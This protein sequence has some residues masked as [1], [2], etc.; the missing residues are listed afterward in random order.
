MRIFGLKFSVTRGEPQPIQQERERRKPSVT[1][2]DPGRVS[3]P[4][5]TSTGMLYTLKDFTQMVNPSFRVEVIQLI[6]DLYKVNPDMGKGMTDMMELTNT[7]HQVQFPNNSDQEAMAMNDHLNK[8]TKK[9]SNYTAGIDGLVNKMIAQIFI[10]GAISVEGVP[11]EDLTGLSTIVFVKP[12]T[13]VFKRE[14]NGVYQPYQHSVGNYLSKGQHNDY[15]KLNTQTYKYV[16][17]VNDT[18]E[19]YGIPP[20]MPALDS[21]KTQADMKVNIKH[22]MENAGI[23]GFM[24]ALMEK[25]VQ[26]ANE[27]V[28][29]Y[30]RRLDRELKKLKIRLREGMKDGLVVGYKDDHEFKMNST[31]KDMSNIDKPWT[32]NQQSVANGLGINSS[33]IGVNT[34]TTTEGGAG[35]NLSKLISQLKVIQM[36]LSHTL[37][38][39]YSLELRLAGFN[40]KGIKIVW[41]P[42]TVSDDVKIQQAKQYKVQNLNALYRDGIISLLQYAQEMGY[43][44]P[45]QDEPRVDISEQVNGKDKLATDDDKRQSDKSKSDRRVRDKNN[46][47]P[48]RKDQNPQPR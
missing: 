31:T 20:F 22:I 41:Y 14:H 27:N 38:F 3:A 33:L 43:D 28:N 8:V 36:L 24:E 11:N 15:I 35:I 30:E 23:L 13:I 18:D 39:L 12:D 47:N 6:R 45:D 1:G 16:G 10:G 25:P 37:E 42:A 21:L 17:L 40:N 5:N 4:D 32:M 44:Q 26:T 29:M 19:P 2:I 48:K 9:W 34:S 46:P 7:G